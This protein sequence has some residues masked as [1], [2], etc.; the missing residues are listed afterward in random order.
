[1]LYQ[2]SETQE[3]RIVD[4]HKAQMNENRLHACAVWMCLGW[5]PILKGERI[6]F[7]LC[8]STHTCG[9]HK[10]LLSVILCCYSNY[11]YLCVHAWCWAGHRTWVA[12]RRES[13][14]SQF[15]S[16]TMWVLGSE[17]KSA[18]LHN[19]HSPTESPQLPGARF[20]NDTYL[21]LICQFLCV[22]VCVC[23]WRAQ[24]EDNL[25]TG[26]LFTTGLWDWTHH[27]AW[28]HVLFSAEQ[29]HQPQKL[30]LDSNYH[31][32]KC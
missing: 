20:L 32:L 21:L 18:R 12:V 29:S 23:T 31:L 25:W 24:L 28:W 8:E 3:I 2:I 5:E 26:S 14:R 22:N 4:I 7:C 30:C 11:T 9:R 27:Q 6:V 15:S 1:M 13:W 19:R 17:L 10:S 16:S